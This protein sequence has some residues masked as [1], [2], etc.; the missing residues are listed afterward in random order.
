MAL[1]VEYNTET[2]G[3]QTT[4][5]TFNNIQQIKMTT[6]CLSGKRLA[7]CYLCPT[8]STYCILEAIQPAFFCLDCDPP[9]IDKC[10]IFTLIRSFYLS[11]A[12][13]GRV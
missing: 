7:L 9:K 10:D 3:T 6:G 13:Y 4:P 12:Q 1:F 2:E 5:G 8:I 11:H